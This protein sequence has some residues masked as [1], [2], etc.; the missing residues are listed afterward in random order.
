MTD[1]DLKTD[2][3]VRWVRHFRHFPNHPLH[4]LG[5]AI[6]GLGVRLQ[7]H[8]DA[9]SVRTYMRC[10]YSGISNNPEALA[11]A[12]ADVALAEQMFAVRFDAPIDNP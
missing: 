2:D 4:R 1:G 7:S 12:F 5:S 6:T 9:E 3:F 10:W 8:A 11:K